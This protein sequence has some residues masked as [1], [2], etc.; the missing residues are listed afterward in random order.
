MTFGV[1]QLSINH[2]KSEY[3][4]SSSK[5]FTF[6]IS[7]SAGR[8]VIDNL[9]VGASLNYTFNK[10]SSSGLSA[11]NNS[12]YSVGPWVEYYIG[13]GVKGKPY[14]SVKPTYGFGHYESTYTGGPVTKQSSTFL[15]LIAAGGYALFI[16]SSFMV[17]FEAGYNRNKSSYKLDGSASNDTKSNGLYFGVGVLATFMKD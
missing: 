15:N 10:Y 4:S 9:L 8:F 17:R 11:T 1:N 16:N 13:P 7:P 2:D 12:T 3:P 6:S 5:R 14:L